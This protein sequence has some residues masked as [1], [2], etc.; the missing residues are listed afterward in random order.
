MKLILRLCLFMLVFNTVNV[1][2][3]PNEE[4]YIWTNVK[5]GGGGFV[6]G[7]ITTPSQENLIYVRTDVGGAYRWNE[8]TQG[9]VP[10]LDWNSIN[11]TGY[12]GVESIAIDPSSPNKVYMLAGTDYW[13]NGLT[14]ILKSDDYGDSFSIVNVTGQF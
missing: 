13:N 2:A 11:Q 8:T 6:T 9:W 4:G 12:Q 7:I 5:I 3:A 14:A 10:L 1:S